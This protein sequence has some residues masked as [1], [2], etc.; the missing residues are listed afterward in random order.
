M[1]PGRGREGRTEGDR[2]DD[3]SHRDRGTRR[4]RSRTDADARRSP[5]V[6]VPRTLPPFVEKEGEETRDQHAW[7]QEG[8]WRRTEGWTSDALNLTHTKLLDARLARGGRPGKRKQL[9]GGGWCVRRARNH[10]RVPG[11]GIFRA[12]SNIR[13]EPT[14]ASW[15]CMCS[16]RWSNAASTDATKPS[17]TDDSTQ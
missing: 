5:R 17:F 1:G 14:P 12:S 8:R 10:A 4:R 15:T 6:L 3:R 16:S 9:Q 11:R 7:R 13:R 2:G